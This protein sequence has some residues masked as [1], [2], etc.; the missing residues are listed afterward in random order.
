MFPDKE[1]YWR[2]NPKSSEVC[3]YFDKI[4]DEE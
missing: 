2:F 4:L 3:I 1:I